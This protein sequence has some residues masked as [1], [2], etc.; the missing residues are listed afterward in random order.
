ME[1]GPPS[2]IPTG[3][4]D[5]RSESS[6]EWRDLLFLVVITV[7][8]A[9]ES[10]SACSTSSFPTNVGRDFKVIVF[11]R[12][13]PVEGL[14]IELSIVSG[15]KTV[16]IVKTD[17]KG[18]VEFKHIEPGSYY[19][20]IRHPAFHYSIEVKVMRHAPRDSYRAVTFQWPGWNPLSTQAVSGS[21][22][23]R[24]RTDRPL[25]LDLTGPQ[26]VYRDVQGAKLTL[27][28]AASGEI[29]GSQLSQENGRF[30]FKDVSPGFY[31]LR[32]ETPYPQDA[33]SQ[34]WVYPHDG[35]VP[36]EVDPSSRFLTVDLQLDN[37]I[38]GELAWGR[39]EGHDSINAQ[40]H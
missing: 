23:G 19:V 27:S 29:V 39:P 10:S 24:A 11:D 30:E 16:S 12:G 18:S 9:V 22:T 1:T 40:T 15:D 25:L 2:V 4:D 7:L 31:F 6:A 3:A 28:R 17:A 8:V 36:I 14:Q 32:V 13:N 35:Y 34:Q 21:L 5:S 20:G 26:P 38:C 33:T 37:A